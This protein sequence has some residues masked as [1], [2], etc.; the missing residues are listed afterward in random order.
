MSLKHN[1]MLAQNIPWIPRKEENEETVYYGRRKKSC[2]YNKK[3]VQE[4]IDNP[5]ICGPLLIIRLKYYNS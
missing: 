5:Q 1:T 2:H 4:L 3:P